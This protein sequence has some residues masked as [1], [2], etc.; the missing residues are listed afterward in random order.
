MAERSKL[1]RMRTTNLGCIGNAGLTVALDDIVCLVGANNTG[2]STVL[3]AYEAVVG[4]MELKPEAFN[5]Q[6][7]GQPT[8][9]ELWV[10][11]PAGAGNVDEKW[12]ENKD[13]FLLVRSKWE[14][15]LTGGKPVR[16]TWEP[17]AG[18]YADDGKASGLDTVFNSRLAGQH[19]WRITWTWF[20]AHKSL[21]HFADTRSVAEFLP[22]RLVFSQREANAVHEEQSRLVG[23]LTVA[24]HL[25]R[26]HAFLA[27]ANA[28]EPIGPMSPRQF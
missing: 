26:A 25:P 20:F 2:K 13:G 7:N 12:K 16:S 28:P 18:S 3:L 19:G 14:W 10:H 15:P 23:D 8:T 24:L 22:V 27:G 4:Q 9:V 17:T 1:V 21:I 11:I 5:C 6:A